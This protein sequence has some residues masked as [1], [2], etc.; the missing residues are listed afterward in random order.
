MMPTVKLAP[1]HYHA[2]A[3]ISVAKTPQNP[4]R[5]QSRIGGAEVRAAKKHRMIKVLARSLHPF[6]GL[7]G[8]F[9]FSMMAVISSP[10]FSRAGS[11]SPENGPS[12]HRLLPR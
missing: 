9:R 10:F 4:Q 2:V 1:G 8:G 7:P 3:Q 11:C 6:S 12:W 5:F